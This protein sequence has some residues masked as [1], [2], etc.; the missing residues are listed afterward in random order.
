MHSLKDELTT[1]TIGTGVNFRGL[2]LFPLSRSPVATSEPEYLLF[3]EAVQQGLARI[4]ELGGGGSVP[5]LQFENKG[6]RPVLLVD[7][8]ELVGAKQ[9]RALNLTILA[10]P[11]KTIVIPVSCVEAGRWNMRSNETFS[12]APH[13]M[14]ANA[15]AS[16]TADV[17]SSMRTSG[18][19]RSDQSEVW[20]NIARKAANMNAKSPTGAMS[21]VY[22]R[23]ALSIEGYVHHFTCDPQECGVL[24]A[25]GKHVM[26]MDL[27]DHPATMKRMFSKLLRSYAVDAIEKPDGLAAGEQSAERFIQRISDCQAFTEPAVG[28]GKDVRLGGSA[29]GGALWERNRYV[30]LCAFVQDVC[31][32]L[33]SRISQPGRRRHR[34]EQI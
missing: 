11:K 29:T 14:F 25:L 17:T 26:G 10:P 18:L 33:E 23:H 28:L 6:P 20:S 5:E 7:G 4:V 22:E 16:R 30:H 1:L 32:K 31:P 3:D 21:A 12:P 9:N 15:R 13:V 27:F 34:A 19:R 24:F 8:E 2:T